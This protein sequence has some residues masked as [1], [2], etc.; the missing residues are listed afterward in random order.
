M[1]GCENETVFAEIH[2]VEK[3]TKELQERDC[4]K[5]TRLIH[6]FGGATDIFEFDQI[7]PDQIPG[8]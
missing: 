7:R 8:Y 2:P 4:C 6:D 5:K 3:D 1:L